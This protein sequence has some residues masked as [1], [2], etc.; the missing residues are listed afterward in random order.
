MK[1]MKKDLE[2][3]F[4]HHIFDRNVGYSKYA[5]PFRKLLV[6]LNAKSFI[7][8]KANMYLRTHNLD[9]HKAHIDY[10]YKHK[11]AIFMSIQTMEK[12]YYMTNMAQR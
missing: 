2:S 9:V 11:A 6:S 1:N 3:Y 5:N 10:P 7:R 4:V 8:V 12:L